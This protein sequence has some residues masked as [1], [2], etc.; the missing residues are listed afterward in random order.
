MQWGEGEQSVLS[1]RI[2]RLNNER[3]MRMR[4]DAGGGE[5]GLGGCKSAEDMARRNNYTTLVPL[6]L[7]SQ[8]IA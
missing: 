1:R 8:S 3:A 2:E 5:E 6:D 7:H 4:R